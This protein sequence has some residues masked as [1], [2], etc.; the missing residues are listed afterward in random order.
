MSDI[1]LESALSKEFVLLEVLEVDDV[2]V[3]ASSL[4]RDVLLLDKLEISMNRNPFCL[5]FSRRQLLYCFGK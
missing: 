2:E 3:F 5:D 1:R 4:K